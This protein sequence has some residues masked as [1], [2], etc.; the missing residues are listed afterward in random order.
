MRLAHKIDVPEQ[1]KLLA[2]EFRRR[3]HELYLVGGAVRD[4]LLDARPK[5]FDLATDARPDE[6]IDII[7]AIGWSK[8]L[9][10]RSFGVVRTR[11]P[12]GD[13]YE[14][15]TFREDVGSG[16]HPTSVK[17]TTIESDVMR[18][19]FTINALFYDLF[20]DEV[21]DLVGGMKDMSTK[22]LETVGPASKKFEEDRLRVLRAFRFANRLNYKFSS[23]INIELMRSRSLK[24]VSPERIRDEFIKCVSSCVDVETL[25]T[26]FTNYGM[27]EHI[28]PA[29]PPVDV[30]CIKTIDALTAVQQQLDVRDHTIL[31]AMLFSG[32]PATTLRNLMMSWKY[33]HDEISRV[34][35]FRTFHDLEPAGAYGLRRFA[36]QHRILNDSC[37]LYARLAGS[38]SQELTEAFCEYVPTVSGGD[39]EA[40]GYSGKDI[41]IELRRRE[42]V[43]FRSGMERKRYD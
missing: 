25:F 4:S 31:I 14:I 19:D 12:L 41:G 22:S 7:D 39:L 2:R 18:R 10:G 9:V 36:D 17:F 42:E 16:R 34:T 11:S 13:E 43:N 24:G 29:F 3:D 23:D 33:T 15:A 21:V 27:W 32:V 40:Q 5:D 20:T 26:M 38:P 6:V 8:D 37:Q 1:I 30:A 35:F 28:F